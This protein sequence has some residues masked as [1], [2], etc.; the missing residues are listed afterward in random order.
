MTVKPFPVHHCVKEYPIR[1]KK[2]LQEK[3][4]DQKVEDLEKH[5]SF[6]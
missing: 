2:L 6:M 5:K 4:W 3:K 1:F